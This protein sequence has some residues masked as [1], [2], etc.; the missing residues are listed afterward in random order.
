MQSVLSTHRPFF[1]LPPIALE[2]LFPLQG[3]IS[4]SSQSKVQ[5]VPGESTKPHGVQVG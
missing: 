4:G 2:H 1:H 5:K 3:L